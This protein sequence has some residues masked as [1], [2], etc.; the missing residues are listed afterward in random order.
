MIK[1]IFNKRYFYF[2]FFGLMLIISLLVLHLSI[3]HDVYNS[4]IHDGMKRVDGKVIEIY[5][6]PM[7]NDN[8][9][10]RTQYDVKLEIDLDNGKHFDDYP[11]NDVPACKEGDLI[12]LKYDENLDTLFQ[13][14]NDPVPHYRVTL[15]IICATFVIMSL[16]GMI[17]GTRINDV[18]RRRRLL[19]V[20]EA[21]RKR[22]ALL[23]PEGIDYN[24]TDAYTGYDG[25]EAGKADLNPFIG[26][27]MDY[28]ALYEY[29]KKLDDASYSADTTYS[30]YNE[31]VA[32]QPHADTVPSNNPMDAQYDPNQPYQEYGA[33]SNNPMDAPYDPNQ[34]YQGF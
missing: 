9:I 12:R 11:I 15:Y 5:G 16:A 4:T 24:S 28:N 25:S 26:S 34:P 27:D 30:G 7:V 32:A 8:G 21:N 23:T 18:L 6:H 33:V 10:Q 29:D 22:A 31:G 19:A 1:R 3:D 20:E 2:V 17:M 13:L 14:A